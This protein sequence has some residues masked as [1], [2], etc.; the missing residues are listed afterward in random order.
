MQVLAKSAVEAVLSALLQDELALLRQGDSAQVKGLSFHSGTR[1]TLAQRA[2]D[3]PDEILI[4]SFEWMAL[5]TRVVNFF[6]LDSSGLEDYLLRRYTI[7][8]WAE[9]V[10][11]SRE[12]AST[13]IRF[14]T[15]GSTGTP[16]TFTH[17]FSSLIA[18]VDFF[19][20]YLLQLPTAPTRIVSLVPA[21][22]IYG[23]LFSVLLPDALQVPV[24]RSLRSF[25]LVFGNRLEE[26][27]IVIAFP[28]ML[29]EVTTRGV[30]MA[31]GVQ[32]ICSTGPCPPEVLTG[33]E[34]LGAQPVIEVFGSTD[35]SGIGVR[36]SPAKPFKLMPRWARQG[37]ES[38]YD[39]LLQREVALPDHLDWVDEDYFRPQRRRDHAVS[40]NGVNVFPQRIADIL[41]RHPDV[42]DAR[43]RLLSATNSRGL[44]ALLI[45]DTQLTAAEE[46]QLQDEM[47]DYAV[48]HLASTERPQRYTLATQIP[49]NDMGKEIDWDTTND[50][51]QRGS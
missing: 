4:D 12:L 35:T 11:N 41:S 50:S 3:H 46:A 22:H 48:E 36:N 43:V 45:V 37:S 29:Q 39:H 51:N 2:Q 25:S 15:S 27:D 13:D 38:L 16:T 32:F 7:G 21:H 10:I 18:E 1:L 42:R 47:K 14:V 40:V 6:C 44:K 5:A 28:S 31:A 34:A 24:T 20:N 49:R 9:I 23:F 8:E 30:S 17:P 33:V 19:K 26:G